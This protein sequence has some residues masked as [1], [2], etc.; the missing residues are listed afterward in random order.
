MILF[1]TQK[2]NI[3]YKTAQAAK[4]RQ[5]IAKKVVQD[6]LPKDKILKGDCIEVMNSLPEKSV[7]IIYKKNI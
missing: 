6:T 7:D 3:K 1:M 4:L 5:A 2:I